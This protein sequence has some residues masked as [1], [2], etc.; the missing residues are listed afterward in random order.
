MELRNRTL[1]P[2]ADN[3]ISQALDKQAAI[4]SNLSEMH[5][6]R[7]IRLKNAAGMILGLVLVAKAKCGG[8]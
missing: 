5:M 8:L 6:I 7:G 1:R 2:V 4:M 3:A